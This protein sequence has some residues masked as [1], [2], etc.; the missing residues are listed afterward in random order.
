MRQVGRNRTLCGR[1]LGTVAIALAVAALAS[2]ALAATHWYSAYEG[3]QTSRHTL[4]FVLTPSPR[5]DAGGLP[6]AVDAA[7]CAWLT[8]GELSQGRIG[9][10][11]EIDPDMASGHRRFELGP[12][13]LRG[14]PSVADV[15]VVFY[16]DLGS[17][18]T[19]GDVAGAFSAIG[20]ESGLVPAGAAYALVVLAQPETPPQVSVGT[21]RVA[22]CYAMPPSCIDAGARVHSGANSWFELVVF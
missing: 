7:R 2:P 12:Y 10:M 8:G 17:C 18:A 19:S 22:P 9:W 4:G 11:V 14:G 3:E 6:A 16:R 15:D 13:D 1:V 5:V 20:S 21:P